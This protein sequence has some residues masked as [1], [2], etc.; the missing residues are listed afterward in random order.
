VLCFFGKWTVRLLLEKLNFMRKNTC[1]SHAYEKMHRI[2][3]P[4]MDGVLRANLGSSF[5][6]EFWS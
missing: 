5:R 6:S 2:L 1:E 4:K 3:S